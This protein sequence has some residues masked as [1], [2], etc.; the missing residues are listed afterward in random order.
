M[1]QFACPSC[2]ST[3]SVDD[4]FSGRKQKCPKCGARVLHLKDR[5]VKLLTAGSAL[6]PK[7]A[8]PSSSPTMCE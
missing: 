1:I 7:P 5:E 8:E 3:C 2:S 6:P 4:K